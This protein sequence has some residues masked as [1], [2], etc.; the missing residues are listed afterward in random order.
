M[1]IDHFHNGGLLI[2]SFI[3]MIIGLSNLVSM[4]KIQRKTFFQ[5]RSERLIIIYVKEYINRPPLWKRS[6][7]F[8]GIPKSCAEIRS[9]GIGSQDG[10]Y[11]IQARPN[12]H[13]NIICQNMDEPSPIEFLGGPQQRYWLYWHYAILIRLSA[14][15]KQHVDKRAC[16]ENSGK[17]MEHIIIISGAIHFKTVDDWWHSFSFARFM[18]DVQ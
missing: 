13:L 11:V 7:D 16:L 10:E 9:S 2:Y 5:T 4:W 14:Y 18:R 17:N 1:F 8:I 6:I 12:C 15:D 3:C